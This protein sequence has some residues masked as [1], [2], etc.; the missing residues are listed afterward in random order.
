MLNMREVEPDTGLTE[1]QDGAC[2][3][4]TTGFWRALL[5]GKGS[6]C[7]GSAHRPR[8]PEEQK[9]MKPE[10]HKGG[11]ATYLGEKSS[12]HLPD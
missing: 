8:E 3:I 11:K 7:T 12:K 9:G 1:G 10:K 4:E 5:L 2:F 6:K